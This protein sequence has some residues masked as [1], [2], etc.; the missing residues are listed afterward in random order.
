M[1]PPPQWSQ[2]GTSPVEPSMLYRF[3][4]LC[5]TPVLWLGLRTRVFGGH[6]LRR[7][8]GVLLACNHQCALDPFLIGTAQFRAVHFMARDSLFL[9]YGI[10]TI[11]RAVH[12]FPVRRSSA[13]VAAMRES[14]RRLRAGKCLLVFAE[15]TRTF[16]GRI[17]PCQP[18]AIAIAA[19]ARVP[20]LP[21]VIEG[22]FD[23]WP[24][25]RRF[26]RLGPLWMEFGDPWPAE[27]LARWDRTE[28]AAEL[29][30]RL[31]TLHNQLRRRV[32]RPPIPYP[33]AE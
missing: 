18:G 1:E 29:T 26:P 28:A 12:A 4:Q 15:S 6:R 23:L 33:D 22:A 32:G 30:R 25:Q 3:V 8:G 9:P 13:D 7:R 11:L 16:D 2:P 19:R 21:M 10:G 20:I 31:R 27:E 5:L 14:V 17:Q 24:R